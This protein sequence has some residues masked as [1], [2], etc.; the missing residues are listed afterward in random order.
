MK[1]MP[2]VT[3]YDLPLCELRARSD[4]ARQMLRDAQASVAHPLAERDRAIILR[5]I[6]EAIDSAERLLPGLMGQPRTL[7]ARTLHDLAPNE[8]RL[9]RQRIDAERVARERLARLLG[10]MSPAQT[11]DAL[12]RIEAHESALA[13]VSALWR[14]FER[15]NVVPMLA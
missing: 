14:M 15:T 7:L 10:D 6:A 2:N 1:S 8:R 3:L 5:M 12:E 9:L 11:Q 4:R 13:E